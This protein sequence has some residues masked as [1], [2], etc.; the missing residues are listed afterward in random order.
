MEE[1]KLPINSLR[2]INIRSNYISYLYFL[3][4]EKYE[5]I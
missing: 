1:E 5:K 2:I 3:L 4:C